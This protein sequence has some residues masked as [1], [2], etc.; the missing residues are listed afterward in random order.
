MT[1]QGGQ[2]GQDGHDLHGCVEGVDVFL[3]GAVV[4]T[5]AGVGGLEV[6]DLPDTLTDEVVG[7]VDEGS[8]CRCQ[9][10]VQMVELHLHGPEYSAYS[11]GSAANPP[12]HEP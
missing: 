3:R 1:L 9:S 11:S 4:G 2:L 6:F 8:P 5:A 10:L 12:G 7:E